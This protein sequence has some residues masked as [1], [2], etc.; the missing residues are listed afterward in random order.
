MGKEKNL[1]QEFKYKNYSKEQLII[2][3]IC[4]EHIIAVS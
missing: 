4:I 2:P 1:N 3:I